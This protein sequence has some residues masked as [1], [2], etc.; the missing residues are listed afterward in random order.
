MENGIVLNFSYLFVLD[1]ALTDCVLCQ[2]ERSREYVAI[3][4]SELP[5]DEKY[6]SKK[7]CF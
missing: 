7:A 4:K 3:A 6:L 1:S 5:Y 2:F